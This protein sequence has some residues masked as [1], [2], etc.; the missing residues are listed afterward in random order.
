MGNNKNEIQKFRKE[1]NKRGFFE[2]IILD[3]ASLIMYASDAGISGWMYCLNKYKKIEVEKFKD[4]F[5]QVDNIVFPITITKMFDE[6][7]N[8]RFEF[9]DDL[10]NTYYFICDYY[11]WN[12]KQILQYIIVKED[13][14]SEKQEWCCQIRINRGLFNYNQTI[15]DKDIELLK[16]SIRKSNKKGFNTNI[17]VEFN[18]NCYETATTKVI[19]KSGDKEIILEYPSEGSE[20]DRKVKDILFNINEGINIKKW[21]YNNVKPL[22]KEMLKIMEKD[23]ISIYIGAKLNN[24]VYAEVTVTDNT[25]KRHTYTK[26]VSEE[27]MIIT[28]DI[29]SKKLD[30]FLN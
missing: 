13:N 30:E 4:L 26:V 17:V 14:S 16:T 24:E 29:F 7:D 12:F 22:L 11:Y 18:Y 2:D 5:S 8:V 1:L 3:K 10:G 21:I 6:V 28:T 23:N 15:R 19:R 9:C 27:R 20:F 25:V